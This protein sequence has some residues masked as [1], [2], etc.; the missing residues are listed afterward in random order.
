MKASRGSRVR[1]SISVGLDRKGRRK[2]KEREERREIE[3]ER[4]GQ[5][6]FRKRTEEMEIEK[7]G[8]NE[9]IEKLIK[10]IKKEIKMKKDRRWKE[11]R[12][13]W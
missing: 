1:P 5:R 7:G 12:K 2:G 13:R 8:V 11:S 6:K 3:K 4:S 10:R 9:M